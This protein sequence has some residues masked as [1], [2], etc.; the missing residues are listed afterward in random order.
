MLIN[1]NGYGASVD[2]LHLAPADLYHALMAY[3]SPF[4]LQADRTSPYYQ[5]QDGYADDMAKAQAVAPEHAS[6]E[7]TIYCL[8][9]AAWARRISGVFG[10]QLANQAPDKAHAVLT[11]NPNEQ[12]YTVSVRAPLYQRHGADEVCGQ[13]PTGGGRKA[14]AGINQLPKSELTLFIDTL[15]QY[16]RKQ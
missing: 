7:S 9:N 1:Y 4:A 10:N 2:D 13:F 12:D 15:N 6:T 3:D 16:Y 14:A 8:P 5:L 11:L